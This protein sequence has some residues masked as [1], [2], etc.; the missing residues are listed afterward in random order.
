[1]ANSSLPLPPLELQTWCSESNVNPAYA[2]VV[3]GVPMDTSIA[4]VEELLETVK[5]FGRVRVR[6]QKSVPQLKTDILLCECR[7]PVDPSK[8]PPEIFPH[9]GEL[10]WKLTLLTEPAEEP[11]E[12]AIK[13]KRLLESEGKTLAD[14]EPLLSQESNLKQEHPSSIIRAVGELLEKVRPPQENNAFR[15][16][17]VFSGVTPTPAGEETLENWLE[18]AQLMLDECDCSAKEKRKRIVESVKGPALEI[19]QAIRCNDPDTPPQKFLEAI[20]NVFGTTESGED[21]YFAFRSMQQNP[22]ERLSDFVRRLEKVLTKAVQKGGVPPA[23]RDRARAEQLLRG[24]VESDIMLLQ[25]RLKERLHN[26]PSF[27]ALLSEVRADEDQKIKTSSCS[28]L[29]LGHFLFVFVMDRLTY[30][31]RQ[32]SGL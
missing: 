22:N 16:L 15:R 7:N 21:L 17:R 5:A 23:L 9:T 18:Q 30:K 1:M 29:V 4:D 13:L 27:M 11:D 8:A 32:E 24:A 25:L 2:V 19:I 14:I 20:E 6:A 28:S 12:F 31:V 10:P 3:S 26:P